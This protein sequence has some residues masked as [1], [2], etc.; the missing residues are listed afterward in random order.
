MNHPGLQ[1]KL[2]Q[3]CK[4][5][6]LELKNKELEKKEVNLSLCADDMIV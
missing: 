2:T 5:T 3:Y 6:I 4:S 1:E